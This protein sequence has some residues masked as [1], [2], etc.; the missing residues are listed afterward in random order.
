MTFAI[1]GMEAFPEFEN[2]SFQ[3]T[4]FFFISEDSAA[5]WVEKNPGPVIISLEEGFAIGKT[6]IRAIHPDLLDIAG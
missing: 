4:V 3:K 6:A 2:F 5:A 1:A